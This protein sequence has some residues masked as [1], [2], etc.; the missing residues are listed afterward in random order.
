MCH[1]FQS[2]Q[3]ILILWLKVYVCVSQYYTVMFQWVDN[4]SIRKQL[5]VHIFFM[6][7][8]M[9]NAVNNQLISSFLEIIRCNVPKNHTSKLVTLLHIWFILNQFCCTKVQFSAVFQTVTIQY[10][11]LLHLHI[12][13][14]HLIWHLALIYCTIISTN[15]LCSQ[16]VL[17]MYSFSIGS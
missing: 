4:P 5:T 1:E 17:V 2:F 15:P 11:F 8:V 12:V 3:V 14:A 10:F 16:F 13:R 6:N 7:L 9:K